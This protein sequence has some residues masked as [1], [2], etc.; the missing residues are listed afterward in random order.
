[1]P[2]VRRLLLRH[3][4][5]PGGV[6]HL[7][8][9]AYTAGEACPR[10]R[11]DFAE[12]FWIESGRARH[13]CNGREHTLEAGQVTL[14]RPDDTHQL[15]A[16]R[17]GRFTLVN[18]AFAAEVVA[19]IRRRYFGN[20]RDWPGAGTHQPAQWE[21]PVS[22]VPQL[23][24]RVERLSMAS[25]SRLDLECFLLRVFQMLRDAGPG[26]AR[27]PPWLV[28]ACQRYA[29][30]DTLHGG[31]SRLAELA[32]CSIAHLN[33]VVREAYG[34]TST[35]LINQYRLERAAHQLRM[36]AHPIARIALDCGYDNLG[37]FYRCF[38]RRFRQTPRRYRLASQTPV[39]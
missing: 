1:M 38:T 5:P 26:H 14:I 36:T 20:R 31:A 39:R 21:L 9:T 6:F 13:L 11:H 7:A 29:D 37:Y 30:Q 34:L 17:G 4:V 16:P 24:D 33:R 2:R 8:R 28:E 18:V 19:F 10:H 23:A 3:F 15:R 25:Q 35:D 27:R 32:G 22:A 12:L